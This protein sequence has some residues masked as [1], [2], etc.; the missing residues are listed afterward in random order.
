[1]GKIKEL[2]LQHVGYRIG[3]YVDVTHWGSGSGTLQMNDVYIKPEELSH[4]KIKDAINDGGLG[5]SA[6]T[7]AELIVQEMY[8]FLHAGGM[9][10]KTINLVLDSKQ[11][12]KGN[13][14]I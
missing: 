2:C 1:M 14:G 7:K 8:G 10:G 12:F 6:I 11:C 13:R 9:H 5:V 3:G 4:N